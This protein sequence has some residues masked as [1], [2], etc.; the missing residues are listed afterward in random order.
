MPRFVGR[1]SHGIW[2]DIVAVVVLAIVVLIV[3]GLTGTVHIFGDVGIAH[4]PA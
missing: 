2:L 3:L 4:L 1:R